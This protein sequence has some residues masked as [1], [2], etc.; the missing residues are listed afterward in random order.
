[1]LKSAYAILGSDEVRISETA[2]Q[3]AGEAVPD[4]FRAFNL[5]RLGP[6]DATPAE[7]EGAV[8]AYPFGEG[9]R[10]VIVRNLGGFDPEHQEEI[11]R[12]AAQLAGDEGG[13]STLIVLGPG[14]DRR[15]RPFKVLS[16]LDSQPSGKH[17]MLEAPRAWK[18]DGWVEERAKER[19]ILLDRGAA[20]ALVDLVG[21]DL[22]VLDGE[23]TKLEIY[24]GESTAVDIDAVE[25]VVGRRRGESPWDMARLLVSG[26]GS[27]AQRLAVRLL[28]AGESPVFLL[29]V[30]TRQ[31][32]EA[33]QIRLLL[34]QGANRDT[35]ISETGIKPFAAKDAIAAARRLSLDDFPRML[36]ALKQGDRA[37]K[38]RGGQSE[39]LLQ[40][41]IGEIAIRTAAPVAGR[42]SR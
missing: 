17:I 16:A 19:G 28:S 39:G 42:T 41:V 35:I 13:A 3:L 1:M 32:L 24:V 12:I 30:L 38:S 22:L 15:R 6:G 8:R 21:V 2:D 5:Q 18:T 4:E 29:N 26:D 7:I 31:V 27:A 40:Q 36:R 14:L 34:E 20:R 10:V 33:Y 23:L 37:L 9:R 25:A 11:A